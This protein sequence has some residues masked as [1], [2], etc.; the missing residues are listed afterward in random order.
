[1]NLRRVDLNLLTVFDAVMREG[2]MSRAADTIGMSQPA[3]SLA[4]SRFRHLTGDELFERS[5]HGVRPTPRAIELAG[6]VHRA[7]ELVAL[8]LE[9]DGDFDPRQSHREFNLALGELGTLVLVPQLMAWLEQQQ[10]R[11]TINTL[12]SAGIDARKEMLYGN[13]HLYLWVL[14][15]DSRDTELASEQLLSI[16]N[17][18]LVRADHPLVGD[19]LD[20]ETYC[21]L[22]HVVM[23][24]PGNYGPSLLDRQLWFHNLKR[25]H[26]VTVGSFL[27]FPN[28]IANTDMIGTVPHKLAGF[29]TP[30]HNLKVVPVPAAVDLQWPLYM[31]WPRALT[32]DPAHR[33]LRNFITSSILAL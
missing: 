33:W 13:L 15:P 8:A 9:Q 29:L 28:I 20:L 21:Q 27:E 12:P 16:D 6:P 30:G 17:V 23:R 2:N 5:G 32:T 31:M 3:L 11:I 22:R 7:L 25:V 24:N 18:C 26:A 10:A 19:T 4:I 1:M 14:P